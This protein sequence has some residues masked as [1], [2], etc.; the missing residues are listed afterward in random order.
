M[1]ESQDITPFIPDVVEYQTQVRN[2]QAING[3]SEPLQ[4]VDI[5]WRKRQ[6]EG[7]FL[8]LREHEGV[9]SRGLVS[10]GEEVGC[11]QGGRL[12]R[13]YYRSIEKCGIRRGSCTDSGLK[14]NL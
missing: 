10:A 13:V 1:S 12:A 4:V 11:W 6:N 3:L 7:E 2:R 14:I 9:G 8:E 5:L